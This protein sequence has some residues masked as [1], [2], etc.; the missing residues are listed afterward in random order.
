VAQALS[1]KS[2]CNVQIRKAT[3][4]SGT[5]ADVKVSMASA[6]RGAVTLVRAI[7]ATEGASAWGSNAIYAAVPLNVNLRVR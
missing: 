3:V 4:A 5:T 1:A 2:G 6:F 7:G